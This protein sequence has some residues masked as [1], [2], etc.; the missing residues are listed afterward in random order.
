MAKGRCMLW[1]QPR[2]RRSRRVSCAELMER[3]ATLRWPSRGDDDRRHRWHGVDQPNDT[4]IIINSHTRRSLLIATRLKANELQ[5]TERNSAVSRGWNPER[6]WH[7]K[8]QQNTGNDQCVHVE[9]DSTSYR[10]GV[11]EIIA[12]WVNSVAASIKPCLQHAN[13]AELGP[14]FQNFLRFS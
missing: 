8:R 3:P 10:H 13:S 9:T 5:I 2:E 4:D 7:Q 12:L 6:E 14:D 1:P 11:G